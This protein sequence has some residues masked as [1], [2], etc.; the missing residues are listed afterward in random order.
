MKQ[1][2]TAFG[3]SF[4]VGLLVAL[5]ALAAPRLTSTDTN[6]IEISGCDGGTNATVPAGDYLV[7]VVGEDVNRCVGDA[8]CLTGGQYMPQKLVLRE[9]I[10]VKTFVGSD[11]PGVVSCRSPTQDGGLSL[12]LIAPGT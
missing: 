4:L 7:A 12:T 1:P 2:H 10:G 8:G 11:T 5:T 9:T 6:H 3:L